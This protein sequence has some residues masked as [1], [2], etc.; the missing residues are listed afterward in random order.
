MSRSSAL[1]VLLVAEESAGIQTLRFLDRSEHNVVAVLASAPVSRGATVHS[2]ASK[3]GLPVWPAELV[4]RP[5]LSDT[6]RE[7]EVDL[8]LN[9]HSLYLIRGEILAACRIGAFNLHPGP[10][11]RYAGLN[12]PSWAIY[13][14]EVEHGVTVH[15]MVPRIDA[16]RIAFQE[17][18]PIE[19]GDTGFSLMAKCVRA[20]VPLLGKLADA[21]ATGCIPR[22]EQDATQRSYFDG[23]PAD[24]GL[25]HWTRSARAVTNHVRAADYSPFA[26]PWG[27]PT[28]L[29]RD[30]RVGFVKARV[31]GRRATAPPGR[32]GECSDAGVD[33]AA[34]DEWVVVTKVEVGGKYAPAADVLRAGDHLIAA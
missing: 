13:H 34:E 31:S 14:G 3:L 33:I 20:G 30:V 18:F 16:G 15:E 24:A 17:R 2:A 7:H 10:L 27:H 22:L 4:K 29:V 25:L 1:N 23:K 11:P 5:E 19:S 32:V 26:S 6:V 12:A 21:A 9:V 28:N 8:L